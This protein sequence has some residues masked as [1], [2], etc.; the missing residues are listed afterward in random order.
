MIVYDIE[1][2]RAIL[3]R[4]EEPI[5]G[6]QYADGWNDHAGMGIACLCAFD[7]A[8]MRYRVFM[9]DNL[10]EFGPLV[11][12]HSQVV[13]FNNL[14]FDDR[15]CRAAG[16]EWPAT[17]SVDL[18]ALI[19]R[20][21]GIPDGQHP[22]GLSLDAICQANNLGAK[23]GNGA[24]APVEFQRGNYGSLIDYCLMD[25]AM[26]TKLYRLMAS[27]GGIIDPRTGQWLE[28]AVPA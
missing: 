15:V 24:M 5:L 14:R 23:S 10:A 7:M 20:A 27:R 4:G 16:I 3:G 1:I 22:R 12:K 28:V 21:A 6:I 9:Q 2:A 26:T 8:A 17:K 13:G 11:E 19:W 25:V 18:A